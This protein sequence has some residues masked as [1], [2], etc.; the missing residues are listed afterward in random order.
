[1]ARKEPHGENASEVMPMSLALLVLLA[2]EG[3]FAEDKEEEEEEERE[4]MVG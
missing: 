1:M 2:T 3:R 4:E